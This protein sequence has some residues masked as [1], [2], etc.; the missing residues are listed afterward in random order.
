MALSVV[1]GN[2]SA[3]VYSKEQ[4]GK[5]VDSVF[6]F[7]E[8]EINDPSFILKAG[9]VVDT[10]LA[11]FLRGDFVGAEYF[12]DDSLK[13]ENP[14]RVLA[15]FHKQLIEKAGEIGKQ[16]DEELR[17]R[18]G[19]L[20]FIK[21]YETTKRSAKSSKMLKHK[22][23][24]QIAVTRDTLIDGF[25]VRE[26]KEP[27]KI[28]EY[29]FPDYI[30]T[31][32][33]RE[34]KVEFGAGIWKISGVID[35]PA[36]YGKFPAVVLLHDAGPLDRDGA[37]YAGKPFRDIGWALAARGYAVLR[38]DKRTFTYIK[39]LDS[40][41][42]RITPKLEVTDD[43]L[44]ALKYLRSRDDIIK[45]KIVVFG[46]GL[47]G[48]LAPKVVSLD[49]SVAGMIVMNAPARPLEDA[50]L[51]HVKYVL[52][53]DTVTP[54][55]SKKQ[56]KTLERQ[57]QN[58]KSPALT[59][60][61]PDSL[62]PLGTPASYWLELRG[63]NAPKTAAN[64]KKPILVLHCERSYQTENDDFLLWQAGLNSSATSSKLSEFKLYS[65]LNQLGIAGEDRST[66]RELWRGGNVDKEVID[67]IVFWLHSA[68]KIR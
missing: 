53:L 63:Y 51:S 12:F 50:L 21:T 40:M 29:A 43:A 62:M 8:I 20:W 2:V 27:K 55:I 10:T 39:K 11:R 37:Y 56:I 38:Y 34:F 1:Y 47:G 28:P 3:Q 48:M 5:N 16:T 60:A 65:D 52:S 24:F 57:T 6:K 35:L 61:T 32:S 22:W 30:R 49:T 44:E 54:D 46:L 9:E 33:V 58:V 14:P 42:T 45:D 36:N 41:H 59:I 66:P 4:L 31:D 68:L 7:S 67:D 26:L 15:N 13:I 23:E 64:L 17:A 19:F 25:F 18:E